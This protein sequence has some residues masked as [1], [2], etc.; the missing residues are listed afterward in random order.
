MLTSTIWDI[1]DNVKE[2]MENVTGEQQ[3]K[4]DDLSANGC[5][6]PDTDSWGDR[7]MNAGKVLAQGFQANLGSDFAKMASKSVA[8]LWAEN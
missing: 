2:L 6:T 3:D 5:T 4:Y 8:S 7:L 1:A